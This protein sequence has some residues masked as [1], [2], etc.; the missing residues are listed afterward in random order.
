MNAFVGDSKGVKVKTRAIDTLQFGNEEIDLSAVEQLFDSSQSRA[1]G[2]ALL[3]LM[4]WLS[5]PQ[6]RGKS[7]KQLLAALDQELEAKVHL[8]TFSSIFWCN[9]EALPDICLHIEAQPHGSLL[10]LSI[11]LRRFCCLIHWIYTQPCW[12][13]KYSSDYITT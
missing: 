3:I 2:E 6:W 13:Q 1:I 9:C 11:V 12:V 10:H 7:L 4:D 5:K 8:V